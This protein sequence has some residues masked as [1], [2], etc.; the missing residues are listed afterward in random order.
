[1]RL[2]KDNLTAGLT[3]ISSLVDCFSSFEDTFTQKAHKGFT[4]LYELYMLYSLVYK[5]NME[6]LENALTVDINRA[7]APINTKINDLICRV[8][9]SEENTKLSTD[10]LLENL[11]D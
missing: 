10:L 4:L 11:N 8:N 7:L 6:R 1:M 5:E 3:S 2:D 9:L